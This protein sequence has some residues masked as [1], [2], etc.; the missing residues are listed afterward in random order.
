MTYSIPVALESRTLYNRESNDRSIPLSPS[1]VAPSLLLL[2]L[3]LL[4][5]VV[6]PSL[7][8]ES[9]DADDNHH[10][11]PLTCRLLWGWWWNLSRCEKRDCIQERWGWN[12]VLDDSIVANEAEDTLLSCCCCVGGCEVNETQ[13]CDMLVWNASIMMISK[14]TF[15]LYGYYEDELYGEVDI[16]WYCVSFNTICTPV[17][18]ADVTMMAPKI[19]NAIRRWCVEGK[20]EV[21]RRNEHTCQKGMHQSRIPLYRFTRRT[22]IF[23]FFFTTIAS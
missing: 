20:N 4:L 17:A 19:T 2:L 9:E 16:L 5:F 8:L 13:P 22:A 12:V 15:I 14:N 23:H 18:T 7:L 11:I 3:P 6:S 21:W 1:S 10:F